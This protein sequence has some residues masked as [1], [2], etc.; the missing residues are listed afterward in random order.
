MTQQWK[1]NSTYFTE[2]LHQFIFLLV[3]WQRSTKAINTGT[4]TTAHSN[5]EWE[6]RVQ[7]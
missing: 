3:F 6:E 7:G 2:R 5:E 4:I 1:E